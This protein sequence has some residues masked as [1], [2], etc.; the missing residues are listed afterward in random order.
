MSADPVAEIDLPIRA[1]QKVNK[2]DVIARLDPRDF[3]AEVTRL[4]TQLDQA[5]AKLIEMRKG[6]RTEDVASLQAN[7]D[8]AKARYREAEQ[9]VGR[10]QQLFQE[11]IVAKAR[12]DQDEAALNVAR[13]QLRAA[14]EELKK[15]QAGAREEEIAQQEAVIRGYET[16]LTSAEDALRDATLR[17]P[18]SGII[19]RREVDNFA[20]VQAK[21]TIAELQELDAVDLTFDVPGP[22]VSQLA[23]RQDSLETVAQ[24]DS[25]PDKRFPA[26]L[27]EFSTRADPATQ[28]FRGRVAIT[29]PKGSDLGPK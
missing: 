2:G 8:A 26:K 11:G 20:N 17:A 23:A 29:L 27:I 22:D 15:G 6:A 14:E 5:K 21:E 1:A 18:F 12:M 10:T 3:Q 7:I 24:I 28:T 9:Q 4:R 16:Q 19:A 13:A 25:M